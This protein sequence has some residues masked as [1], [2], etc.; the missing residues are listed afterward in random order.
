VVYTVAAYCL[1][2]YWPVIKAALA[3]RK[4]VAEA[5]TTL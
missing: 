1:V 4:A 3:R 5:P 2:I